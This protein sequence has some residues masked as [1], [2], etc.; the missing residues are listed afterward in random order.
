MDKKQQAKINATKKCRR[1]LVTLNFAPGTPDFKSFSSAEKIAHQRFN[2]AAQTNPCTYCI[3]QGEVGEEG[4]CHLQAYAEFDHPMTINAVQKHFGNMVYCKPADDNQAAMIAYCSKEDTRATEP[5]VYGTPMA[6]NKRGGAE[7]ARTDYKRAL[8]MIQ[9]GAEILD[10]LNDQ[11]H[12]TPIVNALKKVQFEVRKDDQRSWKTQLIV[13]YG[14]PQTGKTTAANRLAMKYG[15]YY[16][17]VR[18]NNGV[19]FDGYNPFSQRVVVI[20]EF[21]GAYMSATQLNELADR[22]PCWAETKGSSTPYLAKTL[23]LTSNYAPSEWYEWDNTKKHLCK[24]ALMARID[25]LAEFRKEDVASTG[26]DGKLVL[27]PKVIVSVTK[28]TLPF[29]D[30]ILS[31][32]EFDLTVPLTPNGSH[33]VIVSPR[34]GSYTRYKAAQGSDLNDDDVPVKKRRIG[35]AGWEHDY[36]SSDVIDVSS[37]SEESSDINL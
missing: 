30:E 7:R 28:G 32:D 22:W 9:E 27:T 10:V 18:G 24:E 11:P 21:T 29:K 12:L 1:Y 20:D 14:D 26:P 37:D 23:I 17:P 2:A 4:T 36:P 15:S 25:V 8:D 3:F 16:K 35:P 33:E 13:L 19:W 31:R 34:E 6:S 5:R